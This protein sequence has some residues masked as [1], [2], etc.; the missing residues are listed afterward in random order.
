M[1]A[2]TGT[3]QGLVQAR[4]ALYFLLIFRQA[5]SWGLVANQSGLLGKFQVGERLPQKN[6]VVTPEI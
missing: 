3:T 4:Q 1:C 2:G 6:K 5:D